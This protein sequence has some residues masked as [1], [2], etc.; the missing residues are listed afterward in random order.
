MAIRNMEAKDPRKPKLK[1]K[2]VMIVLSDKARKEKRKM[3]VKY[4]DSNSVSTVVV[5]TNST[6]VIVR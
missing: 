1:I 5:R 3:L 2:N 4:N 6:T